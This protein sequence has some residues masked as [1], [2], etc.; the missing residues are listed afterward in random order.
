MCSFIIYHT[1]IIR[2][3]WLNGKAFMGFRNP[4]ILIEKFQKKSTQ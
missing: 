2:D 4:L 3:S 1:A